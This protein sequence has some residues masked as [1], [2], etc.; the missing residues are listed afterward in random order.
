M[1]IESARYIKD[2]FGKLICI[3][4]TFTDGTICSVQ[5]GSTTWINNLL[6]AWI[7]NGGV[8]SPAS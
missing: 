5:E 3:E 7:K 6:A 4:V 2:S 8:I 1:E